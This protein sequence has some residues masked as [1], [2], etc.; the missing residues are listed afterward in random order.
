MSLLI[1]NNGFSQPI[2]NIEREPRGFV[3]YFD[4]AFDGAMLSGAYGMIGMLYA[5]ERALL[6]RGSMPL[7]EVFVSVGI[8][9]ITGV[10]ANL[11]GRAMNYFSDRLIGGSQSTCLKV[12]RYVLSILATISSATWI[13]IG[14]GYP[15]TTAIIV[16]LFV[17]VVPVFDIL[18]YRIC[19][20]VL[21][22]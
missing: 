4:G 18:A 15:L 19:V 20:R 6:V 22:L 17:V 1:L 21:N 13:M 16:P 12:T 8:G 3:D 14:L 9:M 11:A 7:N 5:C 2:R 10:T